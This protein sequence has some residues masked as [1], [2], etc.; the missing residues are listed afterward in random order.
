[1]RI[2]RLIIGLLFVTTALFGLSG[3]GGGGGGS[4]STPTPSVDYGKVT[5][6]TTAKLASYTP[7][8]DV[9]N[10]IVY[11]YAKFTSGA[12]NPVTAGFELPAV[13][14]GT[15]KLDLSNS[16]ADFSAS[17]VGTYTMT[18]Y[19]QVS[20]QVDPIQLSASTSQ[21]T[22]NVSGSSGNGGPPQPPVW[23]APKRHR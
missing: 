18:C 8:S 15:W 5:V 16:S 2:R 13:L 14:G 20:T 1:M 3:C 17:M 22:L 7:P 19:V 21:V 12:A 4:S 6:D 10:T 11:V 23:S 9:A